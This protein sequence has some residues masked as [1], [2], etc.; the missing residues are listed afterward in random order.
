M[1]VSTTAR[2]TVTVLSKLKPYL[3]IQIY[4]SKVLMFS[5]ICCLTFSL[6]ALILL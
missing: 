3:R 1:V 5:S 6:V 2:S 4:V